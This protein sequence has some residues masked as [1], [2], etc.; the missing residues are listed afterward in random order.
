MCYVPTHLSLFHD[1]F[2]TYESEAHGSSSIIDHIMCPKF[3]LDK[4]T[5][6]DVIPENVLNTSDH[7]PI[8]AQLHVSFPSHVL[9][10]SKQSMCQYV[11][12]RWD[13]CTEAAIQLL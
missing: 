2:T 7:F 13:R 6:S 10:A 12:P 9:P 11:P 3:F 5:S 8:L 1:F 4:F